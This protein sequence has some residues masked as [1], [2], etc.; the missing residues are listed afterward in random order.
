MLVGDEVD[1]YLIVRNGKRFWVA[2]DTVGYV[3]LDTC[4]GNPFLEQTK[5]D[6]AK[7]ASND[8]IE[9]IKDGTNS[10]MNDTNWGQQAPNDEQPKRYQYSE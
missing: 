2:E 8:M 9:A 4:T 1:S 3:A 6:F 10:F 5:A 7:D